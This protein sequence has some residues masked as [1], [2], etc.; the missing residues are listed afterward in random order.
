M[1]HQLARLFTTHAS[2]VRP[3]ALDHVCVVV[4]DV[5]RAIDWYQRVV[6]LNHIHKDHPCFGS[7]PAFL[8]S[9]DGA[10]SVALLPLSPTRKPIRDH[11]GAHFAIRVDAD[12]FNRARLV[13]P[14][15]LVEERREDEVHSVDVDEQD[16]GLQRSLFFSDP[17][18][19]I[20]EYTFWPE[21]V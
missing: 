13:L 1:R 11:R 4:R 14:A 2:P 15:L 8:A 16:Y 10:V 5:S 12:D 7:D 20:L 21:P 6:G 17:D 19:N 3:R 9:E 18:A